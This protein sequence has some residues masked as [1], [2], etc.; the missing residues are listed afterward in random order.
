VKLL[1]AVGYAT[2]IAALTAI[3]SLIVQGCIIPKKVD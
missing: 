1:L 3:L 2:G